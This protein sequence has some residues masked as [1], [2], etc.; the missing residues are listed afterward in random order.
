MSPQFE[1]MTNALFHLEKRYSKVSSRK[2]LT[3]LSFRVSIPLKQYANATN[4]N[5]TR[6]NARIDTYGAYMFLILRYNAQI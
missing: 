5:T 4:A 1:I 6:K 2:A 3:K